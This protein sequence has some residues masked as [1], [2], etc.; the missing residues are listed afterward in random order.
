MKIERLSI[1]EEHGYMVT[2]KSTSILFDPPGRLIQDGI[3]IKNISSHMK[4]I[5]IEAPIHYPEGLSGIFISNSNSLGVFFTESTLPIY[6]TDTIYLQIK[7]KIK[8]YLSIGPIRRTS[9]KTQQIGENTK[10]YEVCAYKSIEN[11]VRIIR[12]SEYIP[13]AYFTVIP[14]SAGTLIGWTAY[15]IKKN[16]KCILVYSYGA[17]GKGP[18][19]KEFE[20]IDGSASLL[21]S[22]FHEESLPS[23][24]VFS[25][26]LLEK[27]KK[28][29]PIVIT[30]DAISQS[31]EIILHLLSLVKE[32]KIY[33]F[34]RAFEKLLR[35]YEI[36]PEL[37]S[38]K[39]SEASKSIPLIITG[40]SKVSTL[41]LSTVYTIPDINN[42][43]ILCDSVK[44]WTFL[45]DLPVLHMA[46][47]SIKFFGTFQETLAYSWITRIY[48]PKQISSSSPPNP[49]VEVISKK[50]AKL[51][52]KVEDTLMIYNTQY[53]CKAP[54]ISKDTFHFRG[55]FQEHEKELSLTCEESPLKRMIANDN[56]KYVTEDGMYYENAR[57]VLKLKMNNDVLMVTRH[58]KKKS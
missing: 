48:L 9:E 15:C 46:K 34:D 32:R 25:S 4:Y 22:Q 55:H 50:G 30:L 12:F 37:F 13:F 28:K 51:P 3:K 58:K 17:P 6:I 27:L 57:E 49:R 5:E 24:S 43:V 53:I 47:Y 1:G 56:K 29:L 38:K 2:D 26:D 20:K 54:S 45:S 42:S 52:E 41:S 44:Y 40:S 39:I 7:E 23:L 33:V 8:K 31:M 10:I 21:T 35:S 18:L 16:D 19:S 14:Q 36:Q 11:R